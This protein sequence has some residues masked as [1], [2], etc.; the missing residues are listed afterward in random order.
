[1]DLLAIFMILIAWLSMVVC[2]SYGIYQLFLS[3][4]YM[5]AMT[6][7]YKP[8]INKWGRETLFNPFNGMWRRKLLTEKGQLHARKSNSASIK[9]VLAMTIPFL[10][11]IITEAITG[12]EVVAR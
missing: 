3:A 2:G 4:K 12:A 9:S 1:M 6:S 11:A 10:L 8:G 7:E 5:F